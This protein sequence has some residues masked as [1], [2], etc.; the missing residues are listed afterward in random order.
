MSRIGVNHTAGRLPALRKHTPGRDG[1]PE[2]RFLSVT[3]T[4]AR[5]REPCEKSEPPGEGR[6]EA[7]T[8]VSRDYTDRAK[9]R[10][11]PRSPPA[12]PREPLGEE[13]EQRRSSFSAAAAKRLRTQ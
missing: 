5:A 10:R 1:S 4:H 8:P 3:R 2:K 12:Q 6:E 11:L 9:A 13:V 7:H